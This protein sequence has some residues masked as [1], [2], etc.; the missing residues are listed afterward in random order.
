MAHKMPH[1]VACSA[2]RGPAPCSPE[3]GTK[4]PRSCAG[5]TPRLRQRHTQTKAFQARM[6]IC[7]N[8][9]GA[10]LLGLPQKSGQRRSRPEPC[11]TFLLVPACFSLF[12]KH[13]SLTLRSSLHGFVPS[14]RNLHPLTSRLVGLYCRTRAGVGCNFAGATPRESLVRGADLLEWSSHAKLGQ[15]SHSPETCRRAWARATMLQVSG[16]FPEPAQE[17]SSSSF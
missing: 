5:Q 11:N 13:R 8:G 17:S 16:Q 3:E 1:N 15:D 6:G 12:E 2:F 9:D 7:R 10:G 14:Y 4:R